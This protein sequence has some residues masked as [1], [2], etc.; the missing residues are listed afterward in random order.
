MEYKN[1][2]SNVIIE[3]MQDVQ[4]VQLRLDIDAMDSKENYLIAHLSHFVVMLVG[5]LAIMS[6]VTM[7]TLFLVMDAVSIAKSNKDG[8]VMQDSLTQYPPAQE[9]KLQFKLFNVEMEYWKVVN[10][11]MMVIIP[12][13]MDVPLPVKL[14]VDGIVQLCQDEHQLV[15]KFQHLN[16]VATALK[17]H[18]STKNVM[19]L[20]E[21][22]EMDVQHYASQSQ[23]MFT[24]R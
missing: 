8:A 2:D 13:V 23:D 1:Q 18:N 16:Y 15:R 7:E 17:T 20:T 9:L 24:H 14:K 12:Q 5:N 19:I 22:V 3:A 11:V 6:F 10:S 21:G 4:I